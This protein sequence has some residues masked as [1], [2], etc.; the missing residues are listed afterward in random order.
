MYSLLAVFAV[1]VPTP[2]PD[3]EP[4]GAAPTLQFVRFNDKGVFEKTERTTQLVPES[5]TETANVN[6]KVVTRVVTVN[7]PVTVERKVI[8]DAGN[9]EFYDLDGKKVNESDWKKTLSAGAVV[10]VSGDGNIPQAAYRKVLKA[11]TIILVPKQPAPMPP[12]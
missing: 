12:K 8:L 9:F 7:V 6:G 1:L 10:A 11:G 5:R 3:P 4:N 2:P